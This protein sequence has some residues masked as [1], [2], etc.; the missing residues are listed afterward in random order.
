MEIESES[1]DAYET[2]GGPILQQLICDITR[3][4]SN[5]LITSDS[6]GLVT[7]LSAGRILC[8]KSVSGNCIVCLELY[9]SGSA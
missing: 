4:H 2:K 5:D 1:A 8:R 7:F 3:L 9:E 6:K